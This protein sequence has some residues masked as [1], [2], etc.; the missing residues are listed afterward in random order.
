VSC[1]KP[2]VRNRKTESQS[3]SECVGVRLVF[4]VCSL[5]SV[6]KRICV[7][8]SPVFGWKSLDPVGGPD[9]ESFRWD[10]ILMCQYIWGEGCATI[11]IYLNEQGVATSFRRPKLYLY[12]CYCYW[13]DV[14]WCDVLMPVLWPP[15]KQNR[16]SKNRKR[17]LHNVLDSY[18]KCWIPEKP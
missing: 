9:S 3:K 2:T 18:L 7:S 12:G 16:E 10:F 5:F 15:L 1:W 4:R 17:K 14:K 13:F 11:Y 6:C 8:F